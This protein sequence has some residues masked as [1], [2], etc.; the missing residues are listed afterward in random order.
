MD[1]LTAR[2]GK[3]ERSMIYKGYAIEHNLYGMGEYTVQY[4]GDDVVFDTIKDAK[5]FI[6]TV[7]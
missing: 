7:E 1:A 3:K 5:H 4:Q 6:D 2:R